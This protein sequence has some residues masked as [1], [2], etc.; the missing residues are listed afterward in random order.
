MP[1]LL[2]SLEIL[3]FIAAAFT[4]A[5]GGMLM[6]LVIASDRSPDPWLAARPIFAAARFVWTPM[7]LITVIAGAV[8][9]YYTPQG[10]VKIWAVIGEAAW[11]F[12]AGALGAAFHLAIRA[13]RE[14][15]PPASVV[16]G[17]RHRGRRNW[18]LWIGGGLTA[19]AYILMAA[20]LS[21]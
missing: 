4:A 15:R 17:R 20:S 13:A 18:M 11:I 3:R 1:A 2:N 9:T 16:A 19:F 6:F 12:G 10:G 8:L 14:G 7:A 21:L 5:G